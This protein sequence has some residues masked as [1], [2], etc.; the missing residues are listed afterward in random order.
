[1]SFLVNKVTI[2]INS[3]CVKV[4]NYSWKHVLFCSFLFCLFF[5]EFWRERKSFIFFFS[6]LRARMQNLTLNGTGRIHGVLCWDFC[7]KS[8]QTR[9]FLVP[10]RAEFSSTQSQTYG[11]TKPPQFSTPHHSR[12]LS[13]KFLFF[14][15]QDFFILSFK[16]FKCCQGLKTRKTS[17]FYYF[18]IF[19]KFQFVKNTLRPRYPV[20][21]IMKP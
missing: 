1:M 5:E 11:I 14:V 13:L 8:D 2:Y 12:N 7:R 9:E 21:Q 4:Q 20:D 17:L 15:F 16:I 3:P 6:P 18:S 10:C 19:L